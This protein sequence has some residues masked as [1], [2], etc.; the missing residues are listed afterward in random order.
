MSDVFPRI[1]KKGEKNKM[2]VQKEGTF[3]I[4]PKA[5][6]KDK[7]AVATKTKTGQSREEDPIKE[8]LKKD[9]EEIQ[10]EKKTMTKD[11][12]KSPVD[13]EVKKKLETTYVEDSSS[14]EED[15]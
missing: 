6:K 4:N 9:V 13:E 7:G 12:G 2:E 8:K 11:K 1:F 15:A 14:S 3:K 5:N 10:E